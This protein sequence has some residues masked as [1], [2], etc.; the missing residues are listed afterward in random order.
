MLTHSGLIDEFKLSSV[1]AESGSI[2]LV[3]VDMHYRRPIRNP[4]EDRVDV[5]STQGEEG[6]DGL[7]VGYH[8]VIH[9]CDVLQSVRVHPE[10]FDREPAVS[11]FL[12]EMLWAAM[13]HDF[14]HPGVDNDFLVKTKSAAAEA[15]EEAPLEHYHSRF[16]KVVKCEFD[17]VDYATVV[18]EH[19]PGTSRYFRWDDFVPAMVMDTDMCRRSDVL[20]RVLEP[21]GTSG[22]SPPSSDAQ[23]NDLVRRRRSGA[24]TARS[25][26]WRTGTGGRRITPA[27]SRL[28]R[29]TESTASK[30]ESRT[31]SWS[32]SGCWRRS[33]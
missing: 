5:K 27:A 20:R 33:C 21:A 25:A 6:G 29:L 31:T 32:G 14:G 23:W 10:R 2:A 7:R 26:G 15:C 11:R 8:N 30:T 18:E 1:H 13:V 3:A 4:A 24:R 16:G 28:A 17:A 12:Y 22:W 19:E 9:A